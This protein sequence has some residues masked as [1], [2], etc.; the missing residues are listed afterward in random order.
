[1]LD[2]TPTE[3]TPN[4][5]GYKRTVIPADVSP[6]KECTLEPSLQADIDS[7]KSIHNL[8]NLQG[9]L[10]LMTAG[11]HKCQMTVSKYLFN[12]CHLTIQI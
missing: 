8:S 6:S 11:A 9:Q 1:V 7:L 10:T 4:Y 12:M 5:L 3:D 2:R